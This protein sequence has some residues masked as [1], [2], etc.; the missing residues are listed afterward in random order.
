VADYVA[1]INPPKTKLHT[2]VLGL[3]LDRVIESAGRYLNSL[4]RGRYTLTRSTEQT[5]GNSKKG[6]DIDVIDS[7]ILESR[8]VNTLSGGELFLASLSLAFGLAEVVQS[9]SGGIELD[10]IFIDE[11]FGTLD[12]ETLEAAMKALAEIQR[13]GRLVG[14]VSHVSEL[15]DRIPARIEIIPTDSGSTLKIIT[16]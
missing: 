1:G 9:R 11:G 15:K 7:Q 13:E 16:L 8:S 4:S 6:L 10:S 3:M 5:G 2:F 14:I 12:N